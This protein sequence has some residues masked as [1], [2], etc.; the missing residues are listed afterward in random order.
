[1]TL[2]ISLGY[3]AR[4]G[5]DEI[6][7][8]LVRTYGFV[9]VSWADSL[10]QGVNLWHGWDDRHAYG[11]LKEVVCPKWGYTPRFA[12]QN[13]GTNCIRMHHDPDFWVKAAMLK[14]SKLIDDG[15]NVCVPDTRFLNEHPG[16]NH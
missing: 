16:P 6:A 15:Y 10:K 9:K 13:I 8:Y 2:L 4:H 7:D 5:K 12:Y 14:I 1:M 3:R 11:E